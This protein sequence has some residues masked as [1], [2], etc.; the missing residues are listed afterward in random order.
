MG[1]KSRNWSREELIIAFNLYCRMPFGSIDKSNTDIIEVA[2]CINRT[3]S[4]LSMKM[5]NF[6]SLDPFHKNRNVKGLQHGSKQDK[7]IWDEFHE[8]WSGLAY[9]SQ[10]SL[11]E[12]SKTTKRDYSNQESLLGRDIIT[13]TQRITRVRL[14]QNFFHDAVLSSYGYSCAVCKISLYKMLNASHIIPWSVNKLRRADPSNGLSLCVF[15]DRAFD[16]GLFTVDNEYKI[17]LSKE[18]KQVIDAPK[19]YRVGLQEI[20]GDKLSLPKKFN[21]DQEAFAYHREKV[22]LS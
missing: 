11:N 17:V 21:P 7:I 22:F 16:R 12:L 4:A 14:V 13:E 5:S 6:A 18:A 8:D 20:E 9:E 10:K 15:H 3:P 1:Q 19:L 2:K